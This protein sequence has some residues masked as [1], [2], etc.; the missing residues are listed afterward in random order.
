MHLLAAAPELY[1]ALAEAR[2]FVDVL[3]QARLHLAQRDVDGA[4]EATE[5]AE[6]AIGTI[7]AALAKA[8]GDERKPSETEE[9]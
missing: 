1:R 3:R 4:A 7:D 6:R 5:D 8:R 9:K 2:S